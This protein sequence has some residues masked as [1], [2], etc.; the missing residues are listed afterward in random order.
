MPRA[1]QDPPPWALLHSATTPLGLLATGAP[2][3]KACS[4]KL[5]CGGQ[6]RPLHSSG[7]G[8]SFSPARPRGLLLTR[9]RVALTSSP[10][11]AKSAPPPST[12]GRAD[13]APY[14]PAHGVHPQTRV[15]LFLFGGTRGL[16]RLQ[17]SLSFPP[18]LSSFQSGSP[19]PMGPQIQ[20]ASLHI[21][22]PVAPGIT[23]GIPVLLRPSSPPL[24][25]GGGGGGR[26]G[27]GEGLGGARRGCAKKGGFVQGAPRPCAPFRASCGLRRSL[28]PRSA[29]RSPDCSRRTEVSARRRPPRNPKT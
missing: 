4:C 10:A 13:S 1:T 19:R 14:R 18:L 15:L 12:R 5:I 20:P 29:R 9:R 27:P 22:A 3:C 28:R 2:G 17:P 11:A 6:S 7:G 25:P 23:P 8:P 21:K 26:P 24:R 16:S